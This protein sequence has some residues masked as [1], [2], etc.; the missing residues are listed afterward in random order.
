M[1]DMAASSGAPAITDHS[2][3]LNRFVL[4]IVKALLDVGSSLLR[5]GGLRCRA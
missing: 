1:T 2:C 4:V 3:V 5:V